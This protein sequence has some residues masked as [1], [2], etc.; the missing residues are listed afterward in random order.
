M[1]VYV[2]IS[3]EGAPWEDLVPEIYGVY[4][5]EDEARLTAKNLNGYVEQFDLHRKSTLP[6]PSP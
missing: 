6:I 3:M 4:E 2:V 5:D 1:K